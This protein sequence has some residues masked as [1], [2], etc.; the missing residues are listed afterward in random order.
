MSKFKKEV[1][2]LIID[3]RIKSLI[4]PLS[5]KEYK[6][7]EKSIVED[8]C[9]TPIVIWRGIIVDGHN[10]YEICTRRMIPFCVNVKKFNSFDEALAWVCAKQLERR[11][12]TE[13]MRKYLIGKQ[14]DSEKNV[15]NLRNVSESSHPETRRQSN[16]QIARD[17]HIARSSVE[18]YAIY[19]RA[20]DIIR[21]KNKELAYKILSGEYKLSQASVVSLSKLSD[22]R[23]SN[24]EGEFGRR[25]SAYV[26]LKDTKD[27]IIGLGKTSIKD[28]PAYDP[29]AEIVGLAL[30][31]P[32]WVSS[33]ERVESK[34]AFAEA[35]DSAK[36][37]LSSQL[38]ELIKVASN[39]RLRL[40]EK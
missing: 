37:K 39:L 3:S 2:R 4:L 38:T 10:R 25:N 13:E 17:N 34:A 7:L 30:T 24:I 14:S 5:D 21:K 22:E 28:M 19:A 33:I 29:D 20:I 15:Y 12:I 8:G 40:E 16:S 6:D 26:R 18:K 23:I 31:I 32:T 1:H 9:R 11:N 36:S 27:I 35:S